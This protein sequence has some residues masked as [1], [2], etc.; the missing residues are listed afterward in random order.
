MEGGKLLPSIQVPLDMLFQQ[1]FIVECHRAHAARVITVLM[2]HVQY[3]MRFL[4]KPEI[5][6][7]DSKPLLDLQTRKWR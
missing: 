2:C 3:E 7:V 5:T 6:L 1:N 4:D